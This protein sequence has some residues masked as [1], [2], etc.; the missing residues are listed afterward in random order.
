MRMPAARGGSISSAVFEFNN[1]IPNM[2]VELNWDNDWRVLNSSDQAYVDIST[3]NS[4]W[5]TVWSAEGF[6][7]RNSHEAVDLS[8]QLFGQSNFWIKFRSVQPGW[9]WWWAIDN[10]TLILY[11]PLTPSLPPNFLTAAASDSGQYSKLS[12]EP[13]S[14]PDQII[15]YKIERKDGLP[16]DTSQYT[17]I[18]QTNSS[19]FNYND[20]NIEQNHNYTYRIQTISGPGSGSNWGN[21][22]TSY[23]PLITPVE[24]TDFSAVIDNGKVILNWQTSTETNNK[25]FEVERLQNSKIKKLK[26][27][28][29]KIG[30]VEGNGTTT[31]QHNYSYTDN[32]R[33]IRYI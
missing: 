18:T 10:V 12:W 29:E 6:S 24:L 30:F 32:S 20:Y 14:S 7:I 11:G 4:N 17:I 28:W 23:I 3:D 2:L 31:E 16:A 13:G 26:N 21:E 27:S 1:P 8:P 15:G 25:G 5:S 9:D 33:S 19:T 22:A